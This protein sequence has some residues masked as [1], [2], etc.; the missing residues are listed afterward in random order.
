M[1]FRKV[2]VS[3]VLKEKLDGDAEL[4]VMA[5]APNDENR[6]FIETID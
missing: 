4:I 5:L 1:P 6:V 2:K 3:E